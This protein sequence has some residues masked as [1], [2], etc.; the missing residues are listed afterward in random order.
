MKGDQTMFV[1]EDAIE[2]SWRAVEGI[3]DGG[4]VYPY[5]AGKWGPPEADR[6]VSGFK[7]W[8]NPSQSTSS[9]GT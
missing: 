6:L 3:L 2:E 7:P 1:R 5:D 8:H 9:D 4:P